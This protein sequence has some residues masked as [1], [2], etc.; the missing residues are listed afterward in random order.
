MTP[1]RTRLVAL[2]LGLSL[3]LT[4]QSVM[5][6]DDEA[7]GRILGGLIAAGI[8]AKVIDDRK[9][10]KEERKRAAKIEKQKAE[11]ESY[12][13]HGRFGEEYYDDFRRDRPRYRVHRDHDH[14]YRRH[15]KDRAHSYGRPTPRIQRGHAYGRPDH[16]RRNGRWDHRRPERFTPYLPRACRIAG[17]NR[18]DRYAVY[19][20]HCLNRMYRHADR[21][22]V[23]CESLMQT[24]FGV[25]RVYE[26]RC[27]RRAGYR[28]VR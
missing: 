27:L 5:A 8:I 11:Q 25:S 16:S 6:A 2:L 22:P 20:S 9:D 19:S 12:R 13:T 21:L 15:H 1:I 18:G 26:E 3:A 23:R 14:G 7:L 10:R 4:P 17:Y 24:R 28:V